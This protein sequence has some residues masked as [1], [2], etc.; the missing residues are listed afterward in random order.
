MGG[1]FGIA[2]GFG[3]G[4]DGGLEPCPPKEEYKIAR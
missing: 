1:S 4:G 3:E 2:G